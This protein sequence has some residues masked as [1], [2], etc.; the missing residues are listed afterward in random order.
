MTIHEV[1]SL[2][3]E[4]WQCPGCLSR[5]LRV[6]DGVISCGVCEAKYSIHR[7]IPV[8]APPLREVDSAPFEIDLSILVPTLHE[9]DNIGL[10]IKKINE[11]FSETELTY[12]IVILDGGSRDGTRDA[13]L[14][15]EAKVLVQKEKGYGRAL[16]EGF[17]EARGEYIITMD[18]D[19]SHPVS[20]LTRFLGERER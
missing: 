14:S 6:A 16:V 3:R 7:G 17:R 1:N 13:A 19:L 11:S 2:V 9:V 15:L 4:R 18:A 20:L 8:F 5:D 10:L 12:E